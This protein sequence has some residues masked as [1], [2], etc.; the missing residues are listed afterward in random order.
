MVLNFINFPVFFKYIVLSEEA[1]YKFLS[2]YVFIF[3]WVSS[4]SIF[5]IV[6]SWWKNSWILTLGILY[7]IMKTTPSVLPKKGFAL[8]VFFKGFAFLLEKYDTN[9]SNTKSLSEIQNIFF[10][11]ARKSLEKTLFYTTALVALL[12]DLMK[13]WV[14]ESWHTWHT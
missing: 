4:E 7:S 10:W 9:T 3:K 13:G 12:L 1:L 11:K 8:S 6:F 2:F 14:H 5:G